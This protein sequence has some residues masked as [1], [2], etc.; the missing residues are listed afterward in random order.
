MSAKLNFVLN[1]NDILAFLVSMPMLVLYLVYDHLDEDK[2]RM[3]ENKYKEVDVRLPELQRLVHI[4]MFCTVAAGGL[5][6][7]FAIYNHRKK[8]AAAVVTKEVEET[9]KEG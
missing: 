7:L 6:A 8:K 4:W 2:K 5:N 1:I 3:L 9:K